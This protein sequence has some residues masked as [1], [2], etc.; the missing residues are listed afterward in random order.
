[1]SQQNVNIVRQLFDAFNRLDGNAM[2][3]LW[4][5]D[6]E[7]RPAYIGGGLLEG[8]S[9]RGHEG[10]PEFVEL[11]SETWESVVVEPLEMR[12]LGDQVLAEVRLRA[13]GRASGVPVERITW[14]VFSL[15]DGKAATGVVYKGREEALRA[16]AASDT[17]TGPLPEVSRKRATGTS[18]ERE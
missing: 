13:V 8:A 17:E 18:A 10:V 16:L 7:W 2:R 5:V 9:F 12:D 6:A 4:T 14:N 15:R 3:D 1:M 11:Q